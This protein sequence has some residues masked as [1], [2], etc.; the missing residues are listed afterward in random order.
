MGFMG[1]GKTTLGAEVAR[2]L[3][4]PFLDLDGCI[5]R[6]TGLTIPEIFEA[7]GEA[8][9]R[10]RETRALRSLVKEPPGIIATGGGAFVVEENR[11]IM[12]Q[13]GVSIWLDVPT[14]VLLARISGEERPLWQSGASAQ[15]LAERRKS[16]YRLADRILELGDDSA[17]VNASKLERLVTSLSGDS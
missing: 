6:E 14:E 1:A 11:R 13:T 12:K 4:V 16:Y 15:G 10:D 5:V 2:R 17:D 8:G 3:S 7:E 9:F